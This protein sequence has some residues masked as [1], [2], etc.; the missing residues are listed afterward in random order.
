MT[1]KTLQRHCD[2][3]EI[4]HEHE[5]GKCPHCGEKARLRVCCV[6]GVERWT[7]D[8]GHYDQPRPLAA[9]PGRSG[10][11]Y[12]DDCFAEGVATE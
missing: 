10:R 6:C 3:P 7:I 8:C 12:C 4:D 9:D 1:I 5:G 2:S 11:V